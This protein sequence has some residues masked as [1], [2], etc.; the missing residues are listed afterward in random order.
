[1]ESDAYREKV[2]IDSVAER[3][4]S[5]TRGGGGWGDANSTKE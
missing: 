4:M 3:G 5:G 1:M 2:K